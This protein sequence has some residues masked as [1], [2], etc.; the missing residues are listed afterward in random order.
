MIMLTNKNM[1]KSFARFLLGASCIVSFQFAS[2]QN[3]ASQF[4]ELRLNQLQIIGSHN[5][6]KP[7][8]E[9]TLWQMI[10]KRDSSAAKSLQYG[11]IKLVDQLNMG[12]RN[13][14]LDVVYDPLGGRYENPLG[15]KLIKDA[16]GTPEPFD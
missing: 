16:G 7:G 8:I 3:E 6:Y 14:E 15:L 13:L 11:H 9:E 2:A 10:Y 5:S 1:K 4:S 12:L